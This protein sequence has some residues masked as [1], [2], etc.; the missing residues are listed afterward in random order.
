MSRKYVIVTGYYEDEDREYHRNLF[1]LWWKNTIFHTKHN[2]PEQ[3]YVLDA[4]SEM[5]WED[6]K[7]CWID[8]PYNLGHVCDTMAIG[9]KKFMH[10]ICGW[11]T[12]TLLGAMLAYNSNTDLIY[13]EQDC[14]AF[15]HWVEEMYKSLGQNNIKLITGGL[16]PNLPFRVEQS[17]FGITN[18]F[19][20]K[21]ITDYMNIKEPDWETIPEHKWDYLINTAW[22]DNF[23]WL[24]F[25]YGRARPV[26]Y[27]K[28]VFYLQHAP[29][30]R[31]LR[32]E[33]FNQLNKRKLI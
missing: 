19:L 16:D 15:G 13:K 31:R 14:L 30:D 28:K 5:P 11:S 23:E 6:K 22:K 25:G 9:K 7:G 24:K 3:I 17:L 10:P 21:F 18:D 20:L 32:E 26:D 4:G 12:S 29:H 27:D 8:M 2:P 1:K 33:E